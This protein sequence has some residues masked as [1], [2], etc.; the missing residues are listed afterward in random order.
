MCAFSG[1]NLTSPGVLD[2]ASKVIEC[3]KPAFMPSNSTISVSLLFNRSLPIMRSI[4]SVFHEDWNPIP[5]STPLVLEVDA[6]PSFPAQCGLNDEVCS[7]CGT[8]SVLNSPDS[9]KC[10]GDDSVPFGTAAD[11]CPIGTVMDRE[12]ACCPLSQH[13]CRG[14]CNGSFREA[15][16]ATGSYS[17]CCDANVKVGG[18]GVT[19]S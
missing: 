7:N 14:T 12:G 1:T 11:D 19:R 5:L 8:C 16:D 3:V 15:L 9:T 4:S 18:V 6:V 2:E 13:D 17:V 10:Y